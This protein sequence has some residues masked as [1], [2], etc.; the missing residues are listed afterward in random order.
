M[1]IKNAN[2]TIGNKTSDLPACS[3]VPQPTALP[4]APPLQLLYFKNTGILQHSYFILNYDNHAVETVYLNN[5]EKRQE[6]LCC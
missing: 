1:S 4:H 2:D 3:A 5:L 6:I